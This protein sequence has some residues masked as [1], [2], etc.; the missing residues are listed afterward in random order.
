[1]RRFAPVEIG[2]RSL[3]QMFVAQLFLAAIVALGAPAGA[4]AGGTPWWH[5]STRMFPSNLPPGQEATVVVTAINVG[6]AQ[7]RGIPVVTESFPEDFSVQA[8]EL[9][10]LPASQGKEE[11]SNGLLPGILPPFCEHTE[12]SAHCEID[13][14]LLAS[15][16][17]FPHF[18]E[19]ALN[20]YE[21]VE[22]RVKVKNEGAESGGE[23]VIAKV[24][25]GEAPSVQVAQ[26]LPVTTSAPAFGIEHFSAVPEEEGGAVDVRAGSHPFQF[27]TSFAINEGPDQTRPLAMTRDLDI[28]LPPGLVGNA[29]KLP[30]CSE[31]DLVAPGEENGGVGIAA[32]VNKC[33]AGSMI[34]VAVLTFDEPNLGFDT[35]AVPVFNLVPKKGEPA[36]FGFEVVQAP[37]ILDTSVRTGSDYGVTVTAH[38]VTELVA[39]I[40]STVTFW[41]VPG[42]KLHDNARGWSCLIGGKW[43]SRGGTEELPECVHVEQAQPPALLSLPTAC[44]RFATSIEGTSW[45]TAANP[46]GVALPRAEYSLEDEFGREL[47]ISGCGNLQFEPSIDVTPEVTRPSSPTGLRVNLH[48]PEEADEIA[49]GTSNAIMKDLSVEL[50]EGV[51]VN[52]AAAAG[53]EACSEAAIGYVAALS[54]PPADL[55]FTSSLPPGWEAGVEFCPS[56]SKLG[57]VSIVSRLLPPGQT[58]KGAVFLAT[59][60]ANP[61]GSLLA[62][63]IVAEDPQSGVAVKLA[64]EVSPDPN[65]GRLTTTFRNIPQLPIEDATLTFFGGPQAALATPATCGTYTTTA[66]VTPWSENTR[67]EPTSTFVVGTPCPTQRPF[68]PQ[69]IETPQSIQAGGFTNLNTSIVLGDGSQNLGAVSIKLPP[70]F[71]GIL[72]GITLCPEVRANAG[73]C[74]AGS[75]VGHA[76]VRVGVG[77]EPFEV[78]GGQVFLT[79]GYEGAPFGLSIVTQAKAGPFDLG[80]VVVRARI[81][82]DRST[83]QITVV[84]DPPGTTY[85]IPSILKGIPV[86][87]RQVNV[88]IDRSQF[89]FN[90][91]N[92]ASME[93]TGSASS[94]EGGSAPLSAPFRVANCAVLGFAPKFSV[95]TSGKTSKRDGASLKVKLSYPK[96]AFGT[97]AGIA[98]TKVQLPRQLPSRL[99]TLNEACLASVFEANPANCSKHSVVGQARVTTRLLP[100]PLTGPAY[101]VS[102]G[103]EAFPSLTMV[104]TGYGIRI[105][106]VGS[107][108]IKHGITTTTFATV[109]DVPFETFELTLPEGPFSV[110]GA[111]SNL[112]ESKLVMPTEFKAQ[113][114]ALIRQTTHIGVTGCAKTRKGTVSH[115]T[116]RRSKQR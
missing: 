72:K 15:S 105:D 113:N 50:P 83:G 95:T 86:A 116:R 51:V 28:K 94:S 81:E 40:S 17:R 71:S 31:A 93:A 8:V 77:P 2:R 82:V 62:M 32:T 104:L 19:P 90:P 78:V 63:Y 38:D 64:G 66:S 26:P 24:T 91:T 70:G 6:D 80:T 9:Y 27:T 99:S 107:T 29:S 98:R 54:N 100:V 53:L 111:I 92:C 108:H 49:T 45:P 79:E 30:Q 102:H 67:A 34:G 115:A 106:L 14:P 39:F 25:G 110:L 13:L 46:N 21:D 35:A 11:L 10:L 60:D 56:A 44:G 65:T 33:P 88:T 74:D 84:T 23:H 47:G 16:E 89:T 85:G 73:S 112:C 1:M 22:M 101:L 103:G 75:L 4:V 5:L 37:V 3:A 7:A 68:A 96:A 52:S 55:S 109:P 43:Y 69:L 58:V 41:G 97:Q 20:P 36:R 59:Q 12:R 18:T 114:G 61:F 48:M 87:I 57:T 42:D 76:T